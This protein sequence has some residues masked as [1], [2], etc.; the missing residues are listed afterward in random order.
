M[1]LMT[2][3]KVFS[4]AVV[5][6]TGK[7][8]PSE[9]LTINAYRFFKDRSIVQL[10]STAASSPRGVI[11]CAQAAARGKIHPLAPEVQP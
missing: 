11:E 9:Y 2:L 10:V 5:R 1:T 4:R 6:M 8:P 7:A 3:K